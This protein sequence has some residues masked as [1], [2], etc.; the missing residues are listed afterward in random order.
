[1]IISLKHQV[2][3]FIIILVCAYKK[4]IIRNI[5]LKNYSQWCYLSLYYMFSAIQKNTQE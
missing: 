2:T 5:F 3:S 1:M 4:N